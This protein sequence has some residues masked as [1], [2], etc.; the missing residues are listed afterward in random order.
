[1][2]Y[3]FIVPRLIFFRD[4]MSAALTNPGFS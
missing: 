4:L 2:D 3:E 1:M